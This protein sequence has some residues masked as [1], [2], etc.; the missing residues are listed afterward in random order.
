MNEKRE[1]R[2]RN[3]LI[4][5]KILSERRAMENFLLDKTSFNDYLKNKISQYSDMPAVTDEYVK[6]SM[7]YADFEKKCSSLSA[8]IQSFGI[9]RGDF[10]AIFSENHGKWAVCEQAAM[11]CG[12]ICTLRGSAA[13]V[14]E[15]DYILSHS[16]AKGLILR[17]VKIL[18]K[19]KEYIIN[20]NL[21]FVLIMIKSD[22]DEI[23]E[24]NI[25]VFYMDD[26]VEIGKTKEFNPPEQCVDDYAVM[27]YTSG[28]TGN[29]KGVPQTHKNIL[30][31]MIALERSL[32]CMK[33]ENTLQILPVWH[34]YEHIGQLYFLS[35]GCHLHFTT[36]P[37][38][39]NDLAKYKIDM[40]MS[41][42]RIWE[43]IRLGIFQKLKQKV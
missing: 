15:L 23:S 1:M 24:M 35:C 33:G 39:K 11:R 17:D 3:L 13:P 12:A 43:A 16:E 38:L 40:M 26:A 7:T 41:V 34:A 22:N 2:K 21:N 36:L 32:K 18:K 14:E 5:R 19:L 29:P 10:I 31:Q 4:K 28:T 37:R 20:H 9:K 30:S 8:F 25:P 6:E 27:M 42:P